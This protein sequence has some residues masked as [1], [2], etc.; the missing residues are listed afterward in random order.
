[1]P[2]CGVVADRDA[3]VLFV[4]GPHSQDVDGSLLDE[5]FVDKARTSVGQVNKTLGWT[6]TG[7]PKGVEVT[8]LSF[9]GSSPMSVGS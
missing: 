6:T 7:G 2:S 9:M 5:D 3:R 8:M 4:V 1:M